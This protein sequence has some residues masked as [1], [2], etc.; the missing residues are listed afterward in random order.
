MGDPLFC[1][2]E[3]SG[4]YLVDLGVLI[5]NIPSLSPLVRLVLNR[6]VLIYLENI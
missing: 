4:I 3:M 2:I 5:Q 1:F 6:T